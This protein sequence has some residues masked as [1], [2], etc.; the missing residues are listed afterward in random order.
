[1]FF[2]LF[3]RRIDILFL[4]SQIGAKSDIDCMPADGPLH[5]NRIEF[6]HNGRIRLFYG[7]LHLPDPRKLKQSGAGTFRH[8]LFQKLIGVL[9]Q[10]IHQKLTDHTVV[11]G[12]LKGIRISR[13][14]HIRIELCIQDKALSLPGLL[15]I[16]TVIAEK[17]KI[18][19]QNDILHN[20]LL[21]HKSVCF[22]NLHT[23]YHIHGK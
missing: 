3:Q 1:M 6:Q 18:P 20:A 9:G 5:A 23:V 10:K 8:R 13:P 7:N 17:R 2:D 4:I 21:F 14:V 12:I 19:D 11:D 22:P 16:Y 15:L